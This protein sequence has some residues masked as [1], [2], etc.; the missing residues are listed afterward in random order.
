[1]GKKVAAQGPGLFMP[2]V[3]DIELDLDRPFLLRT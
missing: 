3:I 1:M 2:F